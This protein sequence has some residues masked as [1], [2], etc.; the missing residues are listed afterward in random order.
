MAKIEVDGENIYEGNFWDFHPGCH[1]VPYLYD[2]NDPDQW[3]LAS[4]KENWKGR[5]SLFLEIE[6]ILT[7]GGFGVESGEENYKCT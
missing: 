7:E 3:L 4:V 5:R 1:G 2:K 6:R